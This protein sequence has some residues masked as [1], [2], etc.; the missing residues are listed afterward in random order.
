MAAIPSTPTSNSMISA[1]GDGYRAHRRRSTGGGQGRVSV[2]RAQP[3]VHGRA[4]P[5][6]PGPRLHDH[7]GGLTA[8][9]DVPAGF[10]ARRREI[11]EVPAMR[12]QSAF[13][14]VLLLVVEH[15]MDGVA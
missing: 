3:P 1:I 14:P 6:E 9:A 12:P 2:G 4:V 15:V 8:V 7:R 11:V 5:T 13:G 10:A